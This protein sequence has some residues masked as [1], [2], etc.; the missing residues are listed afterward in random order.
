MCLPASPVHWAPLS[1][2]VSYHTTCP[3]HSDSFPV[4]YSSTGAC[5]SVYIPRELVSDRNQEPHLHFPRCLTG[6]QVFSAYR[7][8]SV[9]T[10]FPVNKFQHERAKCKTSVHTILYLS[11]EVK[12]HLSLAIVFPTGI[13]RNFPRSSIDYLVLD[14]NFIIFSTKKLRKLAE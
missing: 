3:T 4:C 2:E 5:I 9:L 8:Q 6:R 11:E 12:T 13:L 1:P 10:H 14:T 7:M